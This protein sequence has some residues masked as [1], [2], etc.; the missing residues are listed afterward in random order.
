LAVALRL[1]EAE[2]P[3]PRVVAVA[4]RV[5]VV[6]ARVVP[7]VTL[8]AAAVERLLEPRI[9]STRLTLATTSCDKLALRVYLVVAERR[10]LA[11]ADLR[12]LPVAFPVVAASL[13]H[14]VAV[15]PVLVE[16]LPVAA[17][18]RRELAIESPLRG[19]STIDG[20]VSTRSS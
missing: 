20:Q 13:E 3:A 12:D 8:V 10:A 19:G 11:A 4:S 9:A 1:V 18:L 2:E 15:P 16:R 17:R 5:L 6:A 7:V 14:P